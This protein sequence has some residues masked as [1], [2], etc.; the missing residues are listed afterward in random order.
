MSTFSD[1]GGS[2][3]RGGEMAAQLRAADWAGSP[4]GSLE[5]WPAALRTALDL[6]L[7][8]DTPSF[9]TWGDEHIAFFNDALHALLGGARGEGLGRPGREA[10]RP[11]WSSLG[12]A[13]HEARTGEPFHG[14][15]SLPVAGP[16]GVG[17]RSFAV[18]LVVVRDEAG[19]AGV[20]GVCI[21]VGTVV[22]AAEAA[23]RKAEEESRAKDEFIA[24]VSHE[25]RAPLGSILIWSQLL[26]GD[27]PD[28]ATLTRALQMIE[29]STR[30]LARLI[31][32]LLDASRVIAGKLQVE[33]APV[34]LGAAVETAVEAERMNASNKSVA[35]DLVRDAPSVR[36]L[37]DSRRLQQVILNLLSNAIKFTPEGGRVQV[38]LLHGPA[39][40]QVEVSDTGIGI[41]SE[42]LPVIFER[43][44]QVNPER[45]QTGL[46]LGLSIARHLVE[47]HGGTIS[48]A[49]AGAGQGSTFVVKLPLLATAETVAATPAL[50]HVQPSRRALE[51]VT[52]L[53]VDDEQDARDAVA[54]L[55]RQAGA[56]V[57][58]VGSAAEALAASREDRFDIVLSDIAMPIEDGYVL[59]RR[60]RAEE[61]TARIPALALT[62]YATVEDRGKALRAGYDQHLAKPVDP[63]QLISVV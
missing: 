7:G 20:Y 16:G 47:L 39:H 14:V 24:V 31:D 52:V 13:A 53:L 51:G 42:F 61:R 46:G 54:V 21:D 50:T 9:V 58:S 33:K 63:A 19:E 23:R 40:A 25:L 29:R 62:A 5:S 15:L 22:G 12:P 35:L 59:V 3:E 34:D 56:G 44:R 49:S 1:V 18:S 55:L 43:F 8:S 6:V 32:D 38:R 28:E 30:S 41:R 27:T 37:G 57:R 60:L 45:P 11:L 48:A 2:L 36:V 10:L 26:R 17:P 4:L